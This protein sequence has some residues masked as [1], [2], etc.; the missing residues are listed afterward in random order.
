MTSVNG[1]VAFPGNSA[2]SAS[3]Y[4]VE[5]WTRALRAD[6]NKFG[7]HVVSVRPGSFNTA[8]Y[9]AVEDQLMCNFEKSSEHVQYLCGG[10]EY[11]K[12]AK[13]FLGVAKPFAQSVDG[14]TYLMTQLL[15]C[16][17]LKLHAG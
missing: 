1:T 11:V 10:E 8:M 4:A 6:L 9:E 12:E 13:S 15:T 5:G 3:K 14:V 16:N 7:I 17:N 2:Y